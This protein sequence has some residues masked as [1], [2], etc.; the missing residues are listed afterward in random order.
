M[1]RQ[2]INEDDGVEDAVSNITSHTKLPSTEARKLV[3]QARLRAAKEYKLPTTVA[4]QDQ[5]P[6]NAPPGFGAAWRQRASRAAMGD[7]TALF[8][9][10]DNLPEDPKS[11]IDV[12]IQQV[13]TTLDSL[14]H[15]LG[16][17]LKSDDNVN[18]NI[19]GWKHAGRDLMQARSE[20]GKSIKLIQLKKN[21]D[22][23]K[24]S[25][26]TKLFRTMDEAEEYAN[27][28]IELNPGKTFK[29]NVY[30]DN[31]LVGKIEGGKF[32]NETINKTA[33]GYKLVSKSGKNLGEYPT[34]AGAEKREQ[35][36]NYFKHQN[37][38]K[39]TRVDQL[40]SEMLRFARTNEQT[41]FVE[42]VK[43][44]Q[45]YVNNDYPNVA[46]Y[47]IENVTLGIK[48]AKR[49][50]YG[51]PSIAED[52]TAGASCSAAVAS[53]AGNLFTEP[54]KRTNVKRKDPT[55]ITGTEKKPMEV[56]VGIYEAKDPVEAIQKKID[57][58]EKKYETA[59]GQ[60]GMAKDARR[61]KGQR[62]L[63][64]REQTLQTKM[65]NIYSEII[66]LTQEKKEL[67][68]TKV[69]EAKKPK[70]VT[71][72]RDGVPYTEYPY[73]EPKNPPGTSMGSK[74]EGNG[75]GSKGSLS[76]LQ[77]KTYK[78]ASPVIGQLKK[79]EVEEGKFVKGPGGVPCDKY[80]KPLPPKTPKIKTDEYGLTG[81]DYDNIWRRVEEVVGNIFPDGDPSDYMPRILRKYGINDFQ[82]D[83]ILQKAAS[84]NGYKDLY[85][86]WDSL[87]KNHGDQYDES[88]T[89]AVSE[90]KFVK[91][92]GGVPCDKYGNPKATAN[93]GK[94]KPKV[95]ADEYGLTD[96]DY[97]NIWR[98]VEDVIS[99]IFPDGDPMN[100]LP[101][102][103]SRYGVSRFDTGDILEKAAQMHGYHDVYAYWDE[104]KTDFHDEN[105]DHRFSEGVETGSGET[106]DDFIEWRLAAKKNNCMTKRIADGHY[107]AFDQNDKQVG[108]WTEDTSEGWLDCGTTDLDEELVNEL[109]PAAHQRYVSAANK[110][111]S[112]VT[113][114]MRERGIFDPEIDRKMGNRA[115][116]TMK[117]INKL[118]PSQS[119][120]N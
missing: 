21:G 60:L 46:K 63:S 118:Q 94:T 84:M 40:V 98:Q 109:S 9:S 90:G 107:Q 79:D 70:G 50:K 16:E 53:N 73:I 89:P 100:Y 1:A 30:D 29:Y 8:A 78:T 119:A 20:S 96:S 99:R 77:A 57:S 45:R 15:E 102:I 24:L 48:E 95:K 58:L 7:R 36:V 31:E 12:M 116:R 33:K 37:E 81:S 17:L 69:E 108:E 26:A 72:M 13:E 42:S 38:S 61:A 22:E 76:G 91:G 86:Y 82:V 87:K 51:L 27:R 56:G 97:K 92:P 83:D 18:E 11:K 110:S 2:I 43:R 52:A 49:S 75:K 55:K 59:K 6:P 106:Y 14:K 93:I 64:P 65:S 34:K 117:S 47:I 66:S 88:Y 114:K 25:D 19:K 41:L 3:R 68:N 113:D 39:A 104:M 115:E 71:T 54:Q 28:V 62:L 44:L 120:F 10:D 101:R 23:S 67:G 4:D 112:E 105:E 32:I 5:D 103:V 74:H 111:R 85:D 80:G 35:Q